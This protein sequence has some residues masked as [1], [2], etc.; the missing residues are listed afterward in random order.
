M[1]FELGLFNV[2]FTGAGALP[3]VVNAVT[4]LPNT[5]ALALRY[6]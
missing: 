1:C 6:E 4:A 3:S 2:A 5:T